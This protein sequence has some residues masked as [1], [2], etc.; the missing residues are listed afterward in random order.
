MN[1]IQFLINKSLPPKMEVIDYLSNRYT[2]IHQAIT[3]R[4]REIGRKS[5][6]EKLML[7]DDDSWIKILQDDGLM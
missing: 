2:T 5:T 6:L 3:K 1:Y 7:A 4:Q